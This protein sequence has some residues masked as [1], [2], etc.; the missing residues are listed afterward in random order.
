MKKV[1]IMQTNYQFEQ[2]LNLPDKVS[3]NYIYAYLPGE[4][5]TFLQEQILFDIDFLWHN[6]VFSRQ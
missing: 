4:M 1:K 5:F 2:G 6:V 3:N